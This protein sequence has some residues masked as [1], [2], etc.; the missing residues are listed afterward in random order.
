MRKTLCSM[1]TAVLLGTVLLG[2]GCS[3]DEPMNP[4][5]NIQLVIPLAEQRYS[6]YDLKDSSGGPDSGYGIGFRD[7]E[8]SLLF[9]FFYDTFDTTKLGDSLYVPPQYD[10]VSSGLESAYFDPGIDD[11]T[12]FSLGQ[13]NPEIAPFHG[14]QT[15]VPPFDFGPTAKDLDTLQNLEYVIVDSGWFHFTITNNL[16]VPIDSIHFQ[17]YSTNYPSNIVVDNYLSEPIPAGGV[18]HD[19]SDLHD[20]RIDQ[21]LTVEFSGSSPGSIPPVMVDTSASVIMEARVGRLKAREAHGFF[22]SQSISK[23][24][25]VV[26]ETEHIIRSLGIDRGMVRIDGVNQTETSATVTIQL[27]NFTNEWGDTLESVIYIPPSSTVVDSLELDGYTLVL[28]DPPSRRLYVYTKAEFDS[29]SQWIHY[30]SDQKVFAT[31]DMDTTTLS[32]IDG[33]ISPV[34]F[35]IGP[36]EQ[37]VEQIPEGWDQLTIAGATLSLRLNSDISAAIETDFSLYAQQQGVIVD[38]VRIEETIIPNQDTLI[39]IEGLE[40]LINARPDMIVIEGKASVGGDVYLAATNYI[41]GELQ[42]DIPMSFALEATMIKGKMETIEDA[43]DEDINGATVEATI[44]NHLPLSGRVLVLAADD[45]TIFTSNPTA[46]DTLLDALIPQPVIANGRVQ[47]EAEA[48][49]LLK[50]TQEKIDRFRTAPTY[51]QSYFYLDG[52]GGDTLSVYGR[53]YLGFSAIATFIFEIDTE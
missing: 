22:P 49:I 26:W 14:V 53:D 37:E 43:I 18:F 44:H 2:A 7:E 8:D 25:F 5:W 52:T 50:L 19:S 1:G 24:S 15:P 51:I 6:V 30:S 11:S 32:F 38:S 48:E 10:S 12:G 20:K 42:V 13:I 21:L 33:I 46:A 27:K 40:R 9:F 4:S 47:E 34:E 16:P 41:V 31:L 23:D 45:S 39:V 17:F 28:P 29:S 35:A 3:F 36:D